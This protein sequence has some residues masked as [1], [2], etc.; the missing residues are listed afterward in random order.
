MRGPTYIFWANLTPL[1]LKAGA[2]AFGARICTAD[3]AAECA[4]DA[5]GK[6]SPGRY[7]RSDT[8]PCI[9]DYM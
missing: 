5:D 2:T 7:S 4:K 1:S 8:P 9:F 6:T 3:T